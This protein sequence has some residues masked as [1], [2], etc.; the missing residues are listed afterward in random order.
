VLHKTAGGQQMPTF[1]PQ[2]INKL[3]IPATAYQVYWDDQQGFKGFGLRVTSA[4]KKT[5]FVQR[6]VKGSGKEVRYTIGEHGVI[7]CDQARAKALQ[8]INGMKE[9]IDPRGQETETKIIATTLQQVLDDYLSSKDLK[10]NTKTQ[11]NWIFNNAFNDWLARDIVSITEFEILQRFES[12]KKRT[13][14]YALHAFKILQAVFKFARRYRMA[15]GKTHLLPINTVKEAL[16]NEER[17]KIQP[18]T[19]RIP[20]EKIGQVWVALQ[21]LKESEATASQELKTLVHIDLVQFLM[22]TGAR[23]SEVTTLTWDKVNL[24]E[25]WWHLPDP[26]N[27]NPVWLPLSNQAREILVNRLANRLPNNQYVFPSYGATGHAVDPRGIMN[28]VSEIAGLR[29]TP[30]DLRRTFTTVGITVCNVDIIKVELLTNH[31]PQ[32]V[33]A[34]HYLETSKLQWLQPEVQKIADCITG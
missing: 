11:Y 16:E 12:V 14:A 24:E 6:R 25:N 4:G 8:V 18:R 33:T 3:P 21:Q 1:K 10:Q 34:R 15:D 7:T 27:R 2:F 30:H 9:G 19:G 17:P 20:N 32:G 29:L 28:L 26:K 31:K 22:L 13:P 5:Y 23:I